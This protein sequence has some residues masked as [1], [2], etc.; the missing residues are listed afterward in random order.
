MRAHFGRFS[1]ERN[2]RSQN[3]DYLF[4][5]SL[6]RLHIF[7]P[8]EKGAR[9]IVDVAQ[10]RVKIDTD[11]GIVLDERLWVQRLL[12]A[13]LTEFPFTFALL[14]GIILRIRTWDAAIASLT[15]E[16]AHMMAVFGMTDM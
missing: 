13:V 9:G 14:Q 12:A 16:G 7:G 3:L 6:F 5:R 10:G 4:V 1:R 15:F 2:E 11:S 8:H